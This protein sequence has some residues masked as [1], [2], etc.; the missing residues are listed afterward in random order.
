MGLLIEQNKNDKFNYFNNISVKAFS[1]F[2]FKKHSF[3]IKCLKPIV[4]KIIDDEKKNTNKNSKNIAKSFLI[5][6]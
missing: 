5:F 2:T 4:F 1:K 3:D 6:I